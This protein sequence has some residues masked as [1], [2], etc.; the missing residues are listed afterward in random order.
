MKNISLKSINIKTLLPAFIAFLLF[1]AAFGFNSIDNSN[2]SVNKRNPVNS[3]LSGAPPKKFINMMYNDK[4]Y[5][6]ANP[7]DYRAVENNI[8]N[9]RDSLNLNAIQI[10][11][12]DGSLSG[13]FEEPLS[14]Y[15][16]YISD[17]MESV[18]NGMLKGY[19]ER[20][21]IVV[22]CYGQRLEYEAEG[23]N[24]GFSY[25]WQMHNGVT[26]SNRTVIHASSPDSP[27]ML[28][29]TIYENAQH[30]DGT[31]F[32]HRDLLTWYI[33][34]VMRINTGLPDTTSIVTIHV[35]D[36]N[37]TIIKSIKIRAGNFKSG[38]VYSGAYQDKYYNLS[39]D[40]SVSGANTS[41][42]LNYRL[43]PVDSTWVFTL[44]K[45][46]RTCKVDFKVYWHGLTDVW[47]DKMIVDDEM[48]DKLFNISNPE[49]DSCVNKIKEETNYFFDG[50]HNLQAF[51]IDE[52]S[53]SMIPCVRFVDSIMKSEQPGSNLVGV[54]ATFWNNR[55]LR[56]DTIGFNKFYRELQPKETIIHALLNTPL[57]PNN[58]TLNTGDF[59]L[60]SSV[61]KSVYNAYLQTQIL[62]DR[63]A[64]DLKQWWP[65]LGGPD[66]IKPSL[67]GT[68]V[69]E[70]SY[71]K[72]K[73]AQYTPDTK[74]Y[75][76]SAIQLYG[77]KP[78]SGSCYSGGKEPTNE[79]ISATTMLGLA[80]GVDGLTWFEYQSFNAFNGIE[81]TK[82]IG[83]LDSTHAT[84][85]RHI[86]AYGQDK[87]KAFGEM[88]GR[89]KKWIPY[90]ETTNWISAYSVHSEGTNHELIDS[91]KS[92]YRNSSS[93]Y[94][95]SSSNNDSAK[96]WEMGFFE[97]IDGGD[98]SKYFMM[99]NRRCVP[100][101]NLGDGDIRQ[102]KIKFDASQ[103]P[104]FNNWKIVDVNTGSSKIFNKNNQGT[105]G[106]LDL[107]SSTSSLG[108]FKPGE[109]KLFRLVPV[110]IDGGTFVTDE[111]INN[112]TF[113][114]NSAVYTNGHDLRLVEGVNINFNTLGQ[115][116]MK[117]GSFVSGYIEQ[118]TDGGTPNFSNLKGQSGKKW[119]GLKFDSTS[120]NM[121]Y[122][123]ISD[124]K[125]YIV[126]DTSNH[127]DSLNFGY[128]V[129]SL[130][131]N[132]MLVRN[133]KFDSDTTGCIKIYYSSG[134]VSSPTIMISYD[135]LK[136]NRNIYS[137]LNIYSNSAVSGTL[138]IDNN[139]VRNTL[140]GGGGTGM[141][142]YGLSHAAISYNNTYSFEHA[143]FSQHSSLNFHGNVF[144]TGAFSGYSY[145]LL[146][147]YSTVFDMSSSVS[148]YNTI[149]TGE[150][151]GVKLDASY[152][153]IRNGG[154]IFGIGYSTSYHLRG[155][156]PDD[157]TSNQDGRGNC[158]R[159][160][161]ADVD[162]AHARINIF[163]GNLT[164][165]NYRLL[166]FNCPGSM[167]LA[168]TDDITQQKRTN[169]DRKVKEDIETKPL[170]ELN[171]INSVD[172]HLLYH[173]MKED[174]RAHEY[175][176][177]E[178]KCRMLLESGEE[179][180]Y[181]T[182]A[183]RK[184]YHCVVVL[185]SGAASDKKELSANRE[186]K[187]TA[188]SKELKTVS[189]SAS[190]NSIAELKSYYEQYIQRYP[191]NSSIINEMFYYVQKCKIALGDYES[192]LRGYRLLMEQNPSSMA[193]LSAKWEYMGVKLLISDKSSS[194]KGGGETE[195]EVNK[196]QLTSEQQNE[197]LINLVE[198]PTDKYD[199]KK[200]TKDDRKTIAENIL[201]MFE[202]TSKK[203]VSKK[204][205]LE[206][207][208]LNGKADVS[209]KRD[210][211]KMEK[212]SAL[213]K[214]GEAKTLDELISL[215]Q[216]DVRQLSEA[217]GQ[218]T[219]DNPQT[220]PVFE[221]SYKLSQNYPNPFNPTTKINYEI[222]DANFVSI[223]I[224]DLLGREI[225]ELVNERQ[226]AGRYIVNFDA[227]KYMLSSGIYF[228]RIKAGDFV[229]T[230]R[231]VL[232]K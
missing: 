49:H 151:E 127:Y 14:S 5:G 23:G 204:N 20:Q 72:N 43:P 21:K 130:N 180:M 228:Y 176:Q 185:S 209:D 124:V 216:S 51:F 90:F 27:G 3:I 203:D 125:P 187:K 123:R 134:A 107:D 34:P 28:C 29:D 121:N 186:S 37:G 135:S 58:L 84:N 137:P 218:V 77:H 181:A 182:D 57:Y 88:N 139:D 70:I 31:D 110:L 219:A 199:K 126:K 217:D 40:L 150:G 109:G 95:F 6:R 230:K 188:Y 74:L 168:K 4:Y 132:N 215:I 167:M 25:K 98:R 46:P 175:K 192:A 173:N 104:V 156:V 153:N 103:L 142:I 80:W 166:N 221:L 163:H 59:C 160:D 22:P 9:Y 89:I 102:L 10:Y 82:T 60:A 119:Y 39:E 55:G 44:N 201:K 105:G 53:V 69:N 224:Y 45:H 178:Q 131:S 93:P 128:A 18:N 52:L 79:E 138:T 113:D 196:A 1:W 158:F 97:P 36:Y 92:I 73:I 115:I 193:G 26:D 170:K 164:P 171:E 206:S 141:D 85:H 7:S 75:Y 66:P 56:E 189:T 8:S 30:S 101:T 140:S 194:N 183:V 106:Y 99:V 86:N 33:K 76:Q 179:G 38:G 12:Y 207:K 87:W 48:G 191:S 227:A 133:C 118:T 174:L 19:Y 17:V 195:T 213:I 81:Y 112:I 62:G 32:T 94:Q 24:E 117:K 149:N 78:V 67:Y 212:L 91:I 177:A 68:V 100:E 169:V 223:K 165:I 15:S 122:T 210:L 159:V 96:Y 11:S 226:D 152:V 120:V 211:K 190:L 54:Q 16:S 111:S 2:N 202:T 208:I 136:V 71:A 148:G 35:T 222:K 116:I 155:Y 108:Y 42:G 50:T 198:D 157:T 197:R 13:R 229:D 184:L 61:S 146:G 200:F 114:C 214:T 162:S 172:N 63:N 129:Y 143:I 231:M 144:S 41:G 64:K 220:S 205:D 225:A 161:G 65:N 154:N 47:F 83:L 232:V 147:W 145:N